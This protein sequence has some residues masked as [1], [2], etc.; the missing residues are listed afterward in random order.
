SAAGPSSRVG[1]ADGSTPPNSAAGRILTQPLRDALAERLRDREQSV[2]LLNRRGYAAFALCQECGDVLACPHCSV[3][4]TFHRGRRV[5]LCHHCGHGEAP[6]RRCERCG[7]DDLSFKGL[8]T[9]QVERVLTEAFPDAR[10]ARM[11]VD[12]TG[13]KWA[14]QEILDR[15]GEGTVDILLG[16][17]M[18]AKGLDFPR[19]TLVGVVNADVGLHLPD[20]RA[21]E[22][23]FQLLA[24]VAGRAG[25]GV[26]GGEVIIQT[27]VPEHYVIRAAVG[28]DYLGFVQRE[29]ALR[30]DPPYPPHV[31]M[32]RVLLSSPI[33]SVA[34]DAA[35]ALGTWLAGGRGRDVAV[36]GP[37]PAP[38]ERLHRRYRWHVLLRGGA[39]PLGRVL[40]LVADGFSPPGS[41]VRL[42]IDRDPVHLL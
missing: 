34:A 27:Y 10:I 33:Q 39:K 26:L 1:P 37:A 14:H 35:D 36:L 42:A 31:R 5:M 28:H 3:S 12:T 41:D 23:T 6:P 32:A 7:S 18:I 17:Q 38:I 25:R 15:V 19:V 4:M 16:T 21:A 13:G 30:R 40:R 22:R 9:E 29:V 20:F 8:G 2:V 11:D 24:Q